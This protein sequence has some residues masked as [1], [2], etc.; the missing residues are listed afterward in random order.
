MEEIDVAFIWLSSSTVF[1]SPQDMCATGILKGNRR[2]NIL[3]RGDT[4][5][6][7]RLLGQKREGMGGGGRKVVKIHRMSK[8]INCRI[9]YKASTVG[10]TGE[11]RLLVWHV[12]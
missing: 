12:V 6:S 2:N 11:V 1:V 5:Q 7:P 4:E 9:H 3:Q 10:R 8:G